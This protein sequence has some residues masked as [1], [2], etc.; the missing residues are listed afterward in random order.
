MFVRRLSRFLKCAGRQAGRRPAGTQDT[1]GPDGESQARRKAFWF[2]F[3][4]FCFVFWFGVIIL[5]FSGV[6]WCCRH[7]KRLSFSLFACNQPATRLLDHSTTRLLDHSTTRLGYVYR[8][9][10]KKRGLIRENE[11]VAKSSA[12]AAF[13]HS[14]RKNNDFLLLAFQCA[15]ALQ[16]T[17]S[18]ASA[19][20]TAAAT[21]ASSILQEQ[22][23]VVHGR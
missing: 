6:V 13:I 18:T 9:L 22:P 20:A 16:R 5:A 7:C 21:A 12:A 1:H 14:K 10:K 23:V 8:Q 17:T 19:S 4:L 11:A 2:G 15:L 3:V